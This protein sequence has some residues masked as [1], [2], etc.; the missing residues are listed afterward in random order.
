MAD[1]EISHPARRIPG[2]KP[3][4]DRAATAA[5]QLEKWLPGRGMAYRGEALK[6]TDGDIVRQKCEMICNRHGH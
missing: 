2:K 5:I 4:L 1:I 6:S 3:V